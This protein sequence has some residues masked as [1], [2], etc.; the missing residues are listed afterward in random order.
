MLFEILRNAPR[1]DRSLSEQ[2]FKKDQAA[3]S[4]QI[5][6]VVSKHLTSVRAIALRSD[7]ELEPA[8][9]ALSEIVMPTIGLMFFAHS[10]SIEAASRS[11]LRPML[12]AAY[13][14]ENPSVSRIKATGRP[15]ES[16]ELA[17]FIASL[18]ASGFRNALDQVLREAHEEDITS[19][20]GTSTA[21]AISITSRLKDIMRPAEVRLIVS[22]DEYVKEVNGK[23]IT[24]NMQE[25]NK[26]VL[27]PE[28][29]GK[30]EILRSGTDDDA[31]HFFLTKGGA[32]LVRR[33][34]EDIE[35]SE[36]EVDWN[37]LGIYK[38]SETDVND[39][40]KY[41]AEGVFQSK[42]GAQVLM[43]C[44]VTQ[45]LESHMKVI[46]ASQLRS[47]V[48]IH[49]VMRPPVSLKSRFSFL[50]VAEDTFSKIVVDLTTIFESAFSIDQFVA[51]E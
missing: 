37:S 33:R 41:I 44:T 20:V 6:N 27:D 19:S 47:E 17:L 30:F 1:E 18:S 36:D 8:I 48:G 49:R 32:T 46:D 22:G 15:A 23:R 12:D 2:F 14:E 39:A 29:T 5:A 40:R 4:R 38:A 13:T 7:D 25:Y 43:E 42:K 21:L 9:S 50:P 10:E 45:A 16:D 28:S 26:G 24:I 31:S 51:Q 11:S 35:E 3:H 34:G